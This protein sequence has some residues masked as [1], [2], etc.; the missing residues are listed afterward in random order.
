MRLERLES[1]EGDPLRTALGAG[2]RVRLPIPAGARAEL[3]LL[4]RKLD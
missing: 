3:G 2:W 1:A 4:T